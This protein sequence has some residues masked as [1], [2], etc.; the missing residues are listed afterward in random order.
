MDACL[1]SGQQPQSVDEAPR[2]PDEE[3]LQTDGSSGPPGG[4]LLPQLHIFS[5]LFLG[6]A[7]CSE[8]Q[9]QEYPFPFNPTSFSYHDA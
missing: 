1:R 7:F 8:P 4:N 2:P 5:H 6:M 9:A 3:G